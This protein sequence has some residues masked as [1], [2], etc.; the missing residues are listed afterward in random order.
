MKILIFN[1]VFFPTQIGGAEKS[2]LNLAV[3]LKKLGH[4]VFVVSVAEEAIGI[5]KKITEP[6]ITCYYIENLNIYWPFHSNENIPLHHKITQKISDIY[7]LKYLNPLRKIFKDVKPD[8]VHTNN[9]KG[10]SV[11]AWKVAKEQN[12]RIVHTLRDYYLQCSKCTMRN[13]NINC[14]TTCSPCKIYSY[15]KKIIS[16]NV[17]CV[18][19]VSNYILNTHI[20]DGFF[21]NSQCK[22]IY[23][24]AFIEHSNTTPRT[25]IGSPIRFGYI[26]RIEDDKGLSLLLTRLQETHTT[27]SFKL[28]VAGDGE[29]KIINRMRSI[30]FVDYKGFMNASDF[31]SCIDFLIV[32]SLWNE[33]MGRVVP[34]AYS[35]GVPVLVNKVGGL[36]ELVK[37]SITGYYTDINCSEAFRA[38]LDKLYSADYK[39]LSEN[40]IQESL[41]YSNE[42]MTN[43]YL[44]A[45]EETINE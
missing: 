35:Y 9:L 21:R 23:N 32:P 1:S 20:Q 33:P 2:V 4:E 22:V 27:F 30:D 28:I 41:T 18:V 36:S 12:C 13:R 10:I 45:F 5:E 25:S 24:S 44:S 29:Q 7:N 34:E 16:R 14:L 6:G 17:H 26:G 31:F 38:A 8:I 39:Q 40:C 15:P 3:G 11:V 43:K 42:V 37:D 19:G